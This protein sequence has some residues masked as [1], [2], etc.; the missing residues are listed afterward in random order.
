MKKIFLLFT[1]LAFHYLGFSQPDM[2][3]SI[4]DFFS[5]QSSGNQANVST[6]A[7][8]PRVK[9]GN[10]QLGTALDSNAKILYSPDGM[11]NFGPY[12]DSAN[13]FNLFNF[14]HWQYIDILAWFGGSASSPILIPSKAWVDAAHKNGVKVI[15][16]VFF[17]PAVYGGS[18]AQVQS[19]LVKDSLGNFKAA[20]KLIEIANY[21]NFDGWIMNC[22]TSCGGAIG[23]LMASFINRLDS[24]YTGELIWYDSMLQNGSVSYQNKLNANNSYFFQHSTGLFTNY[25]WSQAST[26]TSSQTYA[27]GIGQSPFKVYTGAD[28]WPNRN[29]Q[30]AF[31]NYTWIDKIISGGI[32]KT[33]I[34][35]FATNF[36]FNYSGFSN[37]NNDSNDYAN[38]Y[39][40]ERKIFSGND[41]NPF[42]VDAQWKG[43][44]NYITVRSAITT[45][46]FESDFN[47]GHG[48]NYY[49]NGS[50]VTPGSWH[51]MSHQAILPSWT[52]YSNGISINYDFTDAYSGGS[53]LK[54]VAAAG[55]NFS[56]PL[57]STKF[58][59]QANLLD[60]ELA[61]KST[62]SSI[63]SISIELKKKDNGSVNTVFHPALN[64][65]WESWVANSIAV[66]ATDTLVELILSIQ[67]N[68]GFTLNIGKIGVHAD[69]ASS[70]QDTK[71]DAA[72]FKIY[73]NPSN[74]K[75]S[76]SS[77]DFQT[78]TL[79][80]IY[81]LKG[82]NVLNKII[83]KGE[84]QEIELQTPGIYLY[85]FEAGKKAKQGKIIVK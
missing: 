15:G 45:L 13:K 9:S 51:N 56:I 74:G 29:A 16:T 70:V 42:T 64:G 17:A 52:F 27:L 18:P 24:A 67:A 1:L 23:A 20:A 37:F 30:P 73:P 59:T 14:S 4:P 26:V 58:V 65:A 32:A 7:L 25:A 77:K 83:G 40:A 85:E 60:I 46:P 36:T 11:D 57:F 49:N 21:Y 76:V 50:I 72:I 28:L 19:F 61:L 62:S 38:F 68:A 5:W 66:G 71:L 75:F 48:F 2:S 69:S 44:A 22:E 47:T 10:F 63:D 39:A 35:L 8:H 79:F 80:R 41:Q 81:N 43:L 31:S 33:S 84:T 78:K 54:L 82:E 3:L 6:V 53:S 55:G 12:V 34:A